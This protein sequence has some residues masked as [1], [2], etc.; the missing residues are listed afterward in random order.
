MPLTYIS[1]QAFVL[2]IMASIGGCAI[3]YATQIL[4]EPQVKIKLNYF[5]VDCFIAAFLGFFVF[6]FNIDELLMRTSKAMLINCC[7]GYL[8]SKI[9]DVCSY[10][11]Y[12]KLG[13]QTKFNLPLEPKNTLSGEDNDSTRN[14][15]QKPK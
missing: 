6:W 5:L 15:Q 7:V 9:L 10:L 4:D 8:G 2:A 13:I 1:T 3:R 12:S 14:T 11:L